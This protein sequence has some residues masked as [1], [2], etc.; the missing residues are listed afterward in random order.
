MYI[1]ACGDNVYRLPTKYWNKLKLKIMK[2]CV[3]HVYT[4]VKEENSA[5]KNMDVAKQFLEAIKTSET[6]DILLE[7]DDFLTEL[8]L[9]GIFHII[10]KAST[11]S[12]YSVGNAYDIHK[13]LVV[14]RKYID[15]QCKIYDDFTEFF[16]S[17]VKKETKIVIV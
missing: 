11:E 9:Y 6:M 17:S 16:N 7:F 10:D 15:T 8:D 14:L 3:K 5:I 2:T 13:M 12:I 4:L 1:L